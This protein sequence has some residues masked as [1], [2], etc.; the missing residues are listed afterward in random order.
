MEWSW[1]IG[2]KKNQPATNGDM[3]TKQNIYY[4][5][6]MGVTCSMVIW[7][8]IPYRTSLL[9]VDLG[10]HTKYRDITRDLVGNFTYIVRPA[11]LLFEISNIKMEDENSRTTSWSGMCP[12]MAVRCWETHWHSD[13]RL[14]Y[15]I[16]GISEGIV[17]LRWYFFQ[18]Y[19]VHSCRAVIV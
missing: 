7:N 1:K 12:L 2:V 19:G 10:K 6:F 15:H 17:D 14:R 16:S 13:G 9:P 8:F 4:V 11:E 3:T 5:Q 18:L